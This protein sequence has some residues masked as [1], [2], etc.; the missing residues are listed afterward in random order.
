[1]W[2]IGS[3]PGLSVGNSMLPPLTRARS[4]VLPEA[5]CA[6]HASALAR[7]PRRAQSC[8]SVTRC[9]GGSSAIG[10]FS[11][12][13]ARARLRS[14]HGSA[15]SPRST[16]SQKQ[17]SKERDWR[18]PHSSILAQLGGVALLP[19]GDPRLHPRMGRSVHRP[20]S[21]T[22]R[23]SVISPRRSWK[24]CGGVVAWP[25]GAPECWRGNS[26]C[27][28]HASR[29]PHPIARLRRVAR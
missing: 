21:R 10:G 9:E 5:A 11:G 19:E 15:P 26:T 23:L 13:R 25:C 2:V 6:H 20:D 17:L 8:A 7:D 24:A 16:V 3:A 14:Q 28:A 22:P 12:G 4:T 27:C 18:A 29:R 1:V